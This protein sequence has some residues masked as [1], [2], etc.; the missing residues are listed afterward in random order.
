MLGGRVGMPLGIPTRAEQLQGECSRGRGEMM[1]GRVG[2]ATLHVRADAGAA[3]VSSQLVLQRHRS[4]EGGD[5]NA[6]SLKRRRIEWPGAEDSVTERCSRMRAAALAG[7]RM[8][9]RQLPAELAVPDLGTHVVRLSALTR[10][11]ITANTGRVLGR[12][13][14]VLEAVLSYRAGY[15]STTARGSCKRLALHLCLLVNL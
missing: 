13:N 10:T 11:V 2:T 1:G 6:Q 8:H 4:S 12:S 7:Q 14:S 3:G 9:L 15:L 5:E